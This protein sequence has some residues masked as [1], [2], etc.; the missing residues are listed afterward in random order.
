MN[1]LNV[2]PEDVANDTDDSVSVTSS[3]TDAEGFQLKISKKRRRELN[4]SRRSSDTIISAHSVVNRGLTVIF[5]PED[6]SKPLTK[7]NQLRLSELLNSHAPDCVIAIRPNNRLNLLAVDTR[8][9]DATKSLLKVTCL[10]GT[11]VR[12][13]EPQSRNAA[14]AVIKGVD[15]TITTEEL[16]EQLRSTVPVTSLRRLGSSTTIRLTFD[17]EKLPDH[18][19]VGLVRH[20]TELYIDKPIQCR[21]CGK[22]GHVTSACGAQQV[23][24]NCSGLHSKEV[25]ETQSPR[26]SNCGGDHD[27]FSHKCPKWQEEQDISRIR[28]TTHVDYVSARKTIAISHERDSSLPAVP[29]LTAEPKRLDSSNCP[30]LVRG[31][32]PASQEANLNQPRFRPASTELP[33][34][35]NVNRAS[36]DHESSRPYACAVERG[37]FS[38]HPKPSTS[39]VTENA[40]PNQHI[41]G[42]WTT[43]VQSALRQ[44]QQLLSHSQSSLARLAQQVIDLIQPFLLSMFN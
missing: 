20:K 9:N 3:I 8:N 12:A 30:K 33:K 38:G 44:I 18:V 5:V 22:F 37:R 21:R 10:L 40:L 28:R 13:Y 11:S 15:N 19:L 26:C 43:I 41:N 23:C 14:V 31:P 27:F 6:A 17:S 4:A 24:P 32:T 39:Q 1:H 16:R 29:R 25:C 7:L 42:V 35:D 2:V 36:H 34:S